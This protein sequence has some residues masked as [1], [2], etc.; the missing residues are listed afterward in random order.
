V[1][2]LG[3]LSHGCIVSIITHQPRH[4]AHYKALLAEVPGLKHITI[5][6]NNCCEDVS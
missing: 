3:P 5:E 2:R 6:V 4:A 1:W